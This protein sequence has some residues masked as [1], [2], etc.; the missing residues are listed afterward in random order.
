[1]VMSS[2]PG[3]PPQDGQCA[4]AATGPP[5][6]VWRAT[7]GGPVGHERE[8][9]DGEAP[10][11]LG[12]LVLVAVGA[13]LVADPLEYVGRDQPGEPVSQHVARHGEAGGELL[14]PA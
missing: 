9:R 13:A 10:A 8:N 4:R 7:L 3:N 12:Q 1:M 2:A 6:A 11:P 5:H 14:E